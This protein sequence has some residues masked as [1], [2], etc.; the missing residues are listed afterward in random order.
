MTAAL[1]LR[2][3]AEGLAAPLPSLLIEAERV[4]ATLVMGAHGRRQAGVGETFWEYRRHRREDGAVRVDWRRS[5]RSDALFVRENEWEA[6]QS[7]YLWRDAAPGLDYA[8]DP[9][10]PTKARRAAVIQAALAILAV[11]G[12]ERVGVLGTDAPA[13]S[14]RAGLERAASALAEGASVEHALADRSRVGGRGRVVLASDFLEHPDVW[15]ERLS[16]FARGGARGALLLVADPAEEAFPFAG[17]VRFTG[18][19]GAAAAPDLLFGKAEAAQTA[20]HQRYHAHRAALRDIA[21]RAG[22]TMAVART[23]HPASEALL[24]LYAGLAPQSR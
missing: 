19:G 2:R 9:N 7:L 11:R 14:G 24:R 3:D 10:L 4:A 12:G 23:D 22:W 15:A 13:R 6:A 1:A 8:S 18:P 21:G 20:Y 5:A 17:R 16:A